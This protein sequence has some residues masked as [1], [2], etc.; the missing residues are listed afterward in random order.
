MKT[1]MRALALVLAL[2]C[3]PLGT[4]LAQDKPAAEA[5][6]DAAPAAAPAAADEKKDAAP[7]AAA[8]AKPAEAAAAPAAPPAPNKGDIAFMYVATVLVIRRC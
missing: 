4:A 3:A 1:L 5:V 2:G 6:K 8:E 7:A